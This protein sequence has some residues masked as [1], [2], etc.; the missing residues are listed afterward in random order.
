M[1]STELKTK[2]DRLAE[3]FEDIKNSLNLGNKKLKLKEFEIKSSA[4]DFWNDQEKA[5]KLMQEFGD[6]KNEIDDLE[7][8]SS[9]L[10]TL[11]GLAKEDTLSEDF[12][13]DVD[14]LEKKFEKFKLKSFLS[15]DYDSKNA[16]VAIH[17]GQGGTEARG[18]SGKQKQL[19]YQVVRRLVLKARRLRLKV[20]MHTDT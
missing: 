1:N 4:S 2:V 17:A 14:K 5:R 8:I 6:L 10:E 12:V 13:N 20:V 7:T 9:N 3:E 16:L 15:G 11:L 19:K 18:E